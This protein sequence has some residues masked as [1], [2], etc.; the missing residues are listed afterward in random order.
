MCKSTELMHMVVHNNTRLA[1][2]QGLHM[3]L[4]GHMAQ[5]N[6]NLPVCCRTLAKLQLHDTQGWFIRHQPSVGYPGRS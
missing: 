3:L 5:V 4:Y 2:Q 1:E 6:C